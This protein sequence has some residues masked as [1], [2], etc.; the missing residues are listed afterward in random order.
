MP[1]RWTRASAA[2]GCS[3][4][5]TLR[6]KY[7]PNAS[8]TSS[9]RVRCSVFMTFSICL[10]IAGGSETV[11][12]LVSRMLLLCHTWCDGVKALTPRLAPRTQGSCR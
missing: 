2:V 11:K 3:M 9:E 1:R 5:K 7:T 10:A 12:V 6:V 4:G 8:R